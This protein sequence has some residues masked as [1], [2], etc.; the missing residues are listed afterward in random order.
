MDCQVTASPSSGTLW[1]IAEVE[2][3]TGLGKD[4][5]RVWERRYGFP[6]PQ[7]D[8]QGER[9]FDEGQLGRLRLIKRL[10]DRGHRPG[11]VVG[12]PLAE[13]QALLAE[14]PATGSAKGLRLAST[15]AGGAWAGDE[16]WMA[17]LQAD[18]VDTLRQGIRQH[19]LRHGLGMTIE[20][21]I[22]PL[23]VRVGEAWLD[24]RL[25]VYQEHLYT[26]MVQALLREAMA[27][28][29]P[30]RTGA[31]RV[32]LGTVPRERHSLGLLM[33]EC[34]LAIEGCECLP[35]GPSTPLQDIVTAAQRLNA[36][37]VALSFS[38]HS[39]PH[40]VVADLKQLRAQLPA[41]VE[42]WV[43]GSAPVLYS[44]RCPPGVV[45]LARA[46]DLGPQVAAWRKGRGAPSRAA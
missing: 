41:A 39:S 20:Q 1:T 42:V 29:S 3:E 17:W 2:R 32:V 23:G 5:L 10:L 8:A 35:L 43:G 30:A 16:R 24:G 19:L 12:L 46:Q 21:L 6:T 7:R 25:S 34:F 4:T 44:R 18:Q 31:P 11:A 37:V 27:A 28:L 13:Q 15:G 36:D 26:E 22:A 33:A 14:P 45:A 9:R 40:E 38:A